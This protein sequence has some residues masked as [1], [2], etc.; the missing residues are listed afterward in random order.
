MCFVKS[1]T[2]LESRDVFLSWFDL[3]NMRPKKQME[4]IV[5]EK[6]WN[7]KGWSSKNCEM[8][9][10]ISKDI[11]AK[12]RVDSSMGISSRSNVSRDTSISSGRLSVEVETLFGKSTICAESSSG[13]LSSLDITRSGMSSSFVGG[14]SGSAN[15]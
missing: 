5:T 7:A 12:S 14:S 13:R 1:W 9:E 6:R 15:S 10:V 2:Y 11:L 4:D 8:E 3:K